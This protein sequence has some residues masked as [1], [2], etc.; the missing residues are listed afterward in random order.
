MDIEETS[1]IA[2]GFPP[3]AASTILAKFRDFGEVVNYR[4]PTDGANWMIITYKSRS[5]ALRAASQNGMM[6]ESADG[7]KWMIGI[8]PHEEEDSSAE[9]RRRRLVATPTKVTLSENSNSLFD[10]AAETLFFW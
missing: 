6:M 5:Q 7:A 9:S 8:R 3:A 2:F 1:I 4:L 10:R